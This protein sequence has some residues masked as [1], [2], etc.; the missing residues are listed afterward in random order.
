MGQAGGESLRMRGVGRGKHSRS[1][2]YPLLGQAAMHVVGRQQPE[3]AVMVLGVVPGEED[4]AV[5]AAVLDRVLHVLGFVGDEVGPRGST[6]SGQ[7]L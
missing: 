5:G 6:V 3:T 4:V 7:H 1:R 2:R